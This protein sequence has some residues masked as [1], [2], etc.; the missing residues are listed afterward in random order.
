MPDNK[1]QL[2]EVQVLDI[3][4]QVTKLKALMILTTF[5]I[6]ALV[7]SIFIILIILNRGVY[8]QFLDELAD[9]VLRV[10]WRVP[11]L[12]VEQGVKNGFSDA[13]PLHIICAERVDHNG[14]KLEQ[15][16]LV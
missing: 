14:E 2:G 5:L 3:T 8:I 10:L 15:V 1:K 16:L 13:E 4:S 12:N 7:S 11:G 9:E 6:S